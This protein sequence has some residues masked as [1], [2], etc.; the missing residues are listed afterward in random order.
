MNKVKYIVTDLNGTLV[1]AMPTY[2]RIFSEIVKRRAGLDSPDIAE[3][4]VRA[5]GTPWDEQFAHVLEAHRKPTNE[6]PRMMDEFCE[7]VNRE[8]YHLYP[9][10]AEL[11]D[12]YKSDGRKIFITS[13]SGTGAMIKR[14]Y[15]MGIFPDVDYILGFDIF[16]KGPKHIEMLAEKEGLTLRDFSG[17]AV[18]FGDGPGDMRIAKECGLFAIG[19]AQTVSAQSLREAGADMVLEKIGEALSLDL[20]SLLP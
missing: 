2:T 5:T 8:V 1:D 10:V 6:A 16:K 9:G 14:I 20:D 13:G 12:K 4:S 17:Q 15:E 3:Y 7:L 19:V 11:L 18:Y